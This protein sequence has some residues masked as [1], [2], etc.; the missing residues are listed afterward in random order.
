MQYA[1]SKMPDMAITTDV[2]AGFPGE[3]EEQHKNTCAFIE[4]HGFTRLHVFP[5]SD[6]PGTK[7]SKM[8][9]KNSTETK[10]RRVKELIEIGKKKE[11]EFAEKNIGVKRIAL[12][13]SGGK[14][15][16]MTGYTENYIKV[17]FKV[18]ADAIGKLVPVKIENVERGKTY[19]SMI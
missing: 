13:E 10:K 6:R 17:L 2:I 12:A 15:G 16:F 5:Y 8:P 1:L 18:P 11:K 7:A 4:A 14:D 19:A 3:T 9:D